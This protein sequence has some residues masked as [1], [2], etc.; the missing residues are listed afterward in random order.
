LETSDRCDEALIGTDARGGE[1]IW[2][3]LQAA[4]LRCLAS[5]TECREVE[6]AV[7]VRTGIASNTENGVV[8]TAAR[9]DPAVVNDL[10]GWLE[11]VPAT[12]IALDPA[13]GPSLTAAGC[14]PESGAWYMESLIGEIEQ[15]S[16]DVRAVSSAKELNEWL[17]VVRDCGWYDDIEPARRLYTALS[18]EGLYLSDDGAGSAFFSPPVVLL[19]T[20]AVRPHVRRRGIGRSLTRA[21]LLDAKRRGCTTA[22]LAPSPEGGKLYA[23]LGFRTRPQPAGRWFY[24]PPPN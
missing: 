15:L 5:V 2:D 18:Y 1:L 14:A 20:V 4:Y 8:S 24:L 3:E 11:G 9:L 21:R 7:A 16:H 6:G 13:L 10:L 22:I 12:W 17:T 19:N 23:S